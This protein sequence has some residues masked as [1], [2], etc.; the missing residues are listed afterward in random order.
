VNLLWWGSMKN[1]FDIFFAGESMYWSGVVK[2]KV[3]SELKM[4]KA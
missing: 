1:W 4:I 2:L 3:I